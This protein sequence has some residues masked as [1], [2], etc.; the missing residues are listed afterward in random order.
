[1]NYGSPS[2]PPYIK[3]LWDNLAYLRLV[4]G[5]PRGGLVWGGLHVGLWIKGLEVSPNSDLDGEGKGNPI[6]DRHPDL[7]RH[8]V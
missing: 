7:R 6:P 3:L 4:K 8:A 1:M 5:E 2:Y